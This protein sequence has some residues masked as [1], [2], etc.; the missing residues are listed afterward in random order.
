MVGRMIVSPLFV[1]NVI[2]RIEKALWQK[3]QTNKYQNVRRYI[4][5][6]HHEEID[7]WGN[8]V[9]QNF[10]I[11]NQK[12]NQEIDLNATLHS[13]DGELIFQIAVDLGLEVPGLIYSVAEIK[14]IL[15]E[16]Y[17]DAAS[18]FAKA[19]DKIYSD[20]STAIL[21]ANSALERIIKKICT[22]KEIAGYN[23]KDTLYKLTTHILRQFNFLPD[24]NSNLQIRNLGSGL[25]T[26]AQAIENLRSNHTEAHGVDGELVGDPIYAM[27]ILNSVATIGLFLLKH[28]EK[29]YKPPAPEPDDEIPF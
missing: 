8:H 10:N 14:G 22:D 29:H 17:E 23:P 20:P 21:M 27:L 25:L 1:M 3:F 2:D 13:M 11:I 26:A 4:E 16:K 28:Y 15:V 24:K 9:V 6:W 12:N 18:T 5:R 19:H 7:A